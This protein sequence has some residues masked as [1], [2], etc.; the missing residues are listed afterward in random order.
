MENSKLLISILFMFLW[1]ICCLQLGLTQD[2]INVGSHQHLQVLS[3]QLLIK[4]K[5]QEE[6]YQLRSKNIIFD[7]DSQSGEIIHVY[8]SEQ[9]D[10]RCDISF[11]LNQEQARDGLKMAILGANGVQGMRLAD[12]GDE[13][14]GWWTGP[15]Y[16][17]KGNLLILVYIYPSDSFQK[18]LEIDE[19]KILKDLSSS[20]KN[21]DSHSM[22]KQDLTRP[23]LR[24]L[25]KD[26]VRH[27]LAF[28]EEQAQ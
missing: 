3:D 18:N 27:I 19:T 17:R 1:P 9:F 20:E 8:H 5:A 10:V 21:K 2:L 16:V 4:I 12:L 11:C 28:F 7:T 24:D 14:Y 15:V 23:I 6:G 13:A 26:F 25:A 22:K